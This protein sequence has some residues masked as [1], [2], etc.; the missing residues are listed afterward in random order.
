MIPARML[1]NL[2]KRVARQELQLN[3]LKKKLTARLLRL[4]RRREELRSELQQVESEIAAVTPP[5]ISE[6]APSAA[7]SRRRKAGRRAAGKPKATSLRATLV[8]VFRKNGRTLTVSELVDQVRKTG[9]RSTSKDFKNLLWVSL[10]KIPELERD[11]KG[12]YRLR[13]GKA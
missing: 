4:N 2:V 7:V 11:P 6:A 8:D 1:R 10:G 12:G 5:E 9:Y 13:K 3:A